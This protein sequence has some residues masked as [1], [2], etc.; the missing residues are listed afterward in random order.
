MLNCLIPETHTNGNI[1]ES[2]AGFFFFC[3]RISVLGYLFLYL[4]GF[5][6]NRQDALMK[7][8]AGERKLIVYATSI[9]KNGISLGI[10]CSAFIKK[11]KEQRLVVIKKKEEKI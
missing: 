8:E 4:E 11:K 10:E 6:S 2:H 3:I 1:T 5:I 7:K 9:R